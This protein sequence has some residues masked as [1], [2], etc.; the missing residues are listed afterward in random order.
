M[1]ALTIKFVGPGDG[2]WPDLAEKDA[3]GKLHHVK[4]EMQLS[5]LTGGM[6]S[7]AASVALRLDLPN[8]DT[9]LAE[10]SAKLFLLA[11]DALRARLEA[12]EARL[13]KPAS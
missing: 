12:E 13:K 9:V 3:A 5:F 8:G 11:A 10:T 1:P 4:E 6:T 7:G 2:A